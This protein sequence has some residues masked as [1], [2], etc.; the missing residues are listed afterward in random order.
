MDLDAAPPAAEEGGQTNRIQ[1]SA[2]VSRLRILASCTTRSF[3]CTANAR[4]HYCSLN[5]SPPA[6]PFSFLKSV[7]FEDDYQMTVH[8]IE[9][10]NI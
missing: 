5:G 8:A 2:A 10:P 3:W 7:T 4:P 6:E 1:D 9:H